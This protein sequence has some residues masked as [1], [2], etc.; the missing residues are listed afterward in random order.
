MK[1]D[2]IKL[3]KKHSIKT[4]KI[5]KIKTFTGLVYRIEAE[6]QNYFLKIFD[7][8]QQEKALKIK[9]LY[10]LFNNKGI[11]A[12][13]IIL[14]EQEDDR[15]YLLM[16]EIQGKM[17]QD[18]L[19]DKEYSL[20]KIY[21]DLGKKVAQI[22]SIEFEEFGECIDGKTVQEVS[23]LKGKGPFKYWHDMHLE[24]VKDRLKHFKNTDFE[25]YVG[26]IIQWFEYN[27]IKNNPTP[28]L[29]HEDLNKKNIF[30]KN[31]KVSG[32]I[33]VDDSYVG[34]YEEELMRI[35]NGHFRENKE[36]RE[37]FMRGY[38]SVKKLEEGYEKR[39][40]YYYLSRLLVH[41]KC[42]ILYKEDYKKD[43]E[44]EHKQIHEELREY[45]NDN[46]L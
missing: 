19:E 42:I 27:K 15:I 7:N 5:D 28:T 30:V 37:H 1:S 38:T 26:P 32:I 21:Y 35:E 4:N 18:V 36:L 16:T 3:L 33:D 22:H 10:Q 13:Q 31:N 25:Q 14:F 34:H 23:F 6:E 44:K 8:N 45:L 20:E 39:R 41:I 2:I 17:L 43:L 9:S 11:N 12:P 46:A 40:K 29:L 24:L